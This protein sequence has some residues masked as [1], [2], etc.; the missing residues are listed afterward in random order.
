M[1]VYK[2]VDPEGSAAMLCVKRSAGV[3]LRVNLRN[4]LHTGDEAH[5]QGISPH[6]HRMYYYSYSLV[7][8]RN[9]PCE[10]KHD[11]GVGKMC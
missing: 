1:D 7:F 6:H 8:R 11:V 2:D 9:D 4:L 3:T 5:N 10:A